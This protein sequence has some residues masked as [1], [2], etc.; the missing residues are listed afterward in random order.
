MFLP[1]L[2]KVTRFVFR[3]FK[4]QNQFNDEFIDAYLQP[5]YKQYN[6]ELK[7]SALLKIKK[8]YCLGIPLTCAAYTKIYGRKLSGIER[9]YAT[10]TGIITP[11]IDDFTDERTLSNEA[12]DKL[13]SSPANYEAR[14]LEEAVV[15]TI[16]CFLLEKVTSPEGFLYAL[17]QTIQAQHWSQRQMEPGVPQDELRNIT[18]E[19]GAWSHIFFHYIINEVPTQQTID[20]FHLMGGLLQMSNDIFDVYKDFKEGIATYANTCDDYAALEKYYVKECRKFVSQARA[21]PYERPNLEFFITFFV[22]V[23]ARGIVALRMLYKLQKKL[24]GGVLPIEKLERKQLICD[25]E[26]PVNSIKTA[27]FTYTIMK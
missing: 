2:I 10:L 21:L 1:R 24:G 5:F 3:F 15:K 19:K 7:H 12:I 25:M 4:T 26:K 13:T 27:W 23:M 20:T 18:L 9:E 17:K 8:Y 6:K 16:L 11:L 14:T 22:F